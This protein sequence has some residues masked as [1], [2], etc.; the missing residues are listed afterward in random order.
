MRA[1]RASWRQEWDTINLWK[2]CEETECF[3]TPLRLKG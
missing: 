2:V 1:H 3:L